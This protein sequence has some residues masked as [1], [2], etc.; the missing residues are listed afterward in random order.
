MNVTI[1]KNFV[2][3][4]YFSFLSLNIHMTGNFS[5]GGYGENDDQGTESESES[6]SERTQHVLYF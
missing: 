5:D 2:L 6:E 1:I 3:T 4:H